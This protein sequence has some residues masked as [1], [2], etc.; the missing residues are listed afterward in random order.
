LARRRDHTSPTTK[1]PPFSSGRSSSLEREV[2]A[3]EFLFPHRRQIGA[4]VELEPFPFEDRAACGL[5]VLLMLRLVV[6]RAEIDLRL[7][8]DLGREEF[9]EQ[10]LALSLPSI[11]PLPAGVR[12]GHGA[13]FRVVLGRQVEVLIAAL[14]E[15]VAA[16]ILLV[17]PL[18]DDDACDL[19]RIH[20]ACRHGFVPPVG[21]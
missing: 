6:Q 11:A 14:P 16:E 2:P 21:D 18:T 8:H 12:D 17:E 20:R 15:Q 1:F 9:W 4:L 10:Q 3:L 13:P 5:R 19:P 7:G